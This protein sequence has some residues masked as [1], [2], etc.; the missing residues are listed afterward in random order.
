MTSD[1][2]VHNCNIQV[3][4]PNRKKTPQK[5]IFYIELIKASIL[6]LKKKTIQRNYP[7]KGSKSNLKNFKLIFD[8]KKTST[9]ETHVSNSNAELLLNC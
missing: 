4:Y 6:E 1:I 3:I 7:L 5:K 2:V 9:F 8:G